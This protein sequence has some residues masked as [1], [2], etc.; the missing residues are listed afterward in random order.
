[1]FH[2]G[3]LAETRVL[4]SDLEQHRFKEKPMK[5]LSARSLMKASV[6]GLALAFVLSLVLVFAATVSG[7]YAARDSTGQYAGG[8]PGTAIAC[9]QHHFDV[10]RREPEHDAA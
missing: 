4:Y 3:H 5:T 8:D 7:M 10:V 6:L 9:A 1:M 2:F